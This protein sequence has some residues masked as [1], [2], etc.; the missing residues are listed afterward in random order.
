[1]QSFAQTQSSQSET[2]TDMDLEDLDKRIDLAIARMHALRKSN[3]FLSDH[4]AGQ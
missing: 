4:R 1:M 2:S 3:R